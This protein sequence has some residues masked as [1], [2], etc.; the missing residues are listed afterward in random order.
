METI[1]NRYI[2]RINLL[3]LCFVF[4]FLS[5]LFA[6]SVFSQEGKYE[7]GNT[8]CIVESAHSYFKIYW[9]KGEGYNSLIYSENSSNENTT[10]LVEYEYNPN[11]GRKYV[12]KFVFDC[13]DCTT[14][15]YIRKDGKEFAFKKIE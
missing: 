9:A 2:R 10:I 12:G 6:N 15:T 14:G 5:M 1:Q 13:Y 7:V 4:L 8:Y 3:S 11:K